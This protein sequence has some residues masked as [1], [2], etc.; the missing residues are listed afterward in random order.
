MFFGIL[1]AARVCVSWVLFFYIC[2]SI[3]SCQCRNVFFFPHPFSEHF[4]CNCNAQTPPTMKVAVAGDQS[5]LST[6]LRFFVEQLANK[7][8]DWLSYIRFLV[9][10]LGKFSFSRFF[11]PHG[12]SFAWAEVSACPPLRRLP[13]A[14]KVRGLL[15]QSLQQHLHGRAV[16]GAVLQDGTA[17]LRYDDNDNG[18]RPSRLAQLERVCVT[19]VR[20]RLKGKGMRSERGSGADGWGRSDFI[21]AHKT[22]SSA[23]CC[24]SNK[25]LFIMALPLLQRSTQRQTSTLSEL[26]Y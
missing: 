26:F 14:C 12:P 7:T 20:R 16:E 23:A 21:R 1:T 13:P 11:S 22:S 5:Y 6:I 18:M 25:R 17:I 9:I 4:S 24:S 2:K 3:H 19:N 10:P 15:R 8:P